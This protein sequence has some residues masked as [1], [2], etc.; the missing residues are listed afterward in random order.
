MRGVAGTRLAPP[1]LLGAASVAA[2]L[3]AL[4]VIHVAG[5]PD[6]AQLASTPSGVV[7]GHVARLLTSGLVI[8]GLPWV[9]IVLLAAILVVALRELG[10]VRLWIVA[11]AAHVGGTLVAYA[12]VGALW[13]ADRPLSA[14]TIHERDYGVS[15]VFAGELG[16][17]LVHG[18]RRAL[19]PVGGVAGV[20]FAA[21]LLDGWDLG[22]AEHLLGFAVGVLTMLVLERRRPRAV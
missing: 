12:G 14:S 19:L 10:V 3:A 2:Y 20:A 8:D 4:V 15:V 1:R 13:L 21:G 17:L 18:G 9:Q 22:D 5:S 11:I 6:P 7:D 16:A